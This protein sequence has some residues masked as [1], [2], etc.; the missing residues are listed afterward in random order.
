MRV[1]RIYKLLLVELR[2]ARIVRTA[3]LRTW[4]RQRPD[5]CDQRGYVTCA[6]DPGCHKAVGTG[7]LCCT[8]ESE[9]AGASYER[10]Q[11][12]N[13]GHSRAARL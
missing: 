1:A 4:R 13:D 5:P 2:A 8:V 3:S 6:T 12:A 7:V 11:R 10:A 9:Q